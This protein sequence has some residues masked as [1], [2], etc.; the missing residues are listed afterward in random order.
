MHRVRNFTAA[1]LLALG[2]ALLSGG[3][4]DNDSS[5]YI[6]GVFD[7]SSSRCIAEPDSDSVM[8]ANGIIDVEFARGY[9][10]ALLVGSQL[11]ERGSREKLRTETSRLSVEGAHVTLYG[12]TGSQ[13]SYDTTA[14]GIVQPA[15]GTDPGLA[16]IFVQLIRPDDIGDPA[17]GDFGT[18]G[19]PGQAIVRMRVFG[20]TLGGQEIESGDY[21]F[22]IYVC[23][24]CLISYPPEAADPSAPMGTYLCSLAADVTSPTDDICFLGQDQ[25]IPCTQCAAFSDA[26]KNPADNPAYTP[27]P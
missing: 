20:T 3:C 23:R 4:V 11:T 13:T 7:L 5:L 10:A 24:G 27:Q 14:S 15:S 2:G 26:C 12:T 19:P 6:A 21:D 22:T 1:G 8:L 16:S 9:R 17:S 18:L 25:Q